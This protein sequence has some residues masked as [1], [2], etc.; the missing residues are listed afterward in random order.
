MMQ[1][2]KECL[3]LWSFEHSAANPDHCGGLTLI[4]GQTAV[5]KLSPF[6]LKLHILRPSSSMSFHIRPVFL[7]TPTDYDLLTERD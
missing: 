5:A 4:V 1:V 3:T 2:R 6:P 7:E